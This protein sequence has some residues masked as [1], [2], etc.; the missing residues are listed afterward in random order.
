MYNKYNK[1]GDRMKSTR[2]VFLG[3]P[4]FAATI[5][6]G[7]VEQGYAV[8]GVIS[9]P[10]KIV[11]KSKEKKPTPV[12]E[13]ATFYHLPVFQPLHLKEDYQFLIDLAPDLLI[14]CA[15]GQILP[16]AVLDIAKINNIN[17]HASLLPKLRG[18][19]P[20]H[21]AIMNGETKTG[22]TIMQMVK[23]MD[24]GKMYAKKE[25]LLD[26]DINTTELFEKL[27]VL[28]RDLL[29]ATLPSIIDQS[30]KGIEQEESEA[31]Y[32]YNIGREEEKI[33]FHQSC[34]DVHN[35]I[36]GLSFVPGAY[37]YFNGKSFKIFQTK[38]T[39]MAI[40]TAECGTL[41]NENKKLYVRCLDGYLEIC[42]VQLEG[43]KMMSAVDFMNGQQWNAVKVLK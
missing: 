25:I 42:L 34:K 38:Y 41:K 27:Q 4:Q 3:T 19:A 30:N 37:A 16:Q 17:V 8:V 12:K 2:I 32:A 29:L 22:V 23:K 7:L 11:G 13:V 14:T 6:K 18:G 1:A 43:K 5:L 36:R 21:R 9:Q 26:D 31:T 40:D 35:H 10:D 20:I 33:D 28:G 15:Y 24:A 39:T